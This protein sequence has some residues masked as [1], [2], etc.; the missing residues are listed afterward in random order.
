MVLMIMMR[1]W[2]QRMPWPFRQ[3]DADWCQEEQQLSARLWPELKSAG[4]RLGLAR[5]ALLRNR[6][7]YN[8]VLEDLFSSPSGV[9]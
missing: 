4:E 7:S 5:D 1:W 2:R 6:W 9:G 8:P 3:A